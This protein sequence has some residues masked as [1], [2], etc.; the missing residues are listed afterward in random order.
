M[1]SHS[2]TC[3]PTQVNTPRLNR[4]QTVRYSI[5]LPRRD[6]RLSWPRW[7]VT[8]RD[9]LP[10]RRWSP[11]NRDQCQLTMLIKA[12]AQNTTLCCH[13]KIKYECAMDQEL[14]TELLAECRRML[15]QTADAVGAGR[16]LH[17]HSSDGGTFLCEITSWPP[18]WKFY[19][20]EILWTRYMFKGTQSLSNASISNNYKYHN[21]LLCMRAKILK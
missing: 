2:V 5:Y 19:I 15:Q 16:M 9:G 4:S 6:G 10:A 8:Y 7:F 20:S 17:M 12:N 11:I 1:G 3:H 13:E 21:F 14:Q 18:S